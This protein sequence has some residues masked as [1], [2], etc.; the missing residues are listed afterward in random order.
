MGPE[1]CV[2]VNPAAGRAEEGQA[3]IEED[4]RLRGCK[5]EYTSRD[6]DIGQL[7]Y[8]RVIVA[9]GD[10]TL[11]DVINAVGIE[12][13]PTLGLLPLGTANDFA[14]SLGIPLDLEGALDVIERGERHAVDVI[15]VRGSEKERLGINV[16]AGGFSGAVDEELDADVKGRWG[17]FAYLRT[18]LGAMTEL[19]TYDI[20]LRFDDGEEDRLSSFNVAVANGRYVGGGIPVAP[21][22]RFD[23]GLL[24]VVVLKAGTLASLAAL[25]PRILVG[26]H[27]EDEMVE[28]RRARRLEVSSDPP[29]RF[30]VDGELFAKGDL[31]FEVV[32]RALTFIAG[33]PDTAA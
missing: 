11:N 16:S 23:D 18:A 7:G 31:Q 3:L 5:I 17:A 29:M 14:R 22:A 30:N 21:K 10:G 28:Y 27:A 26:E 8:Q 15:R 9:G 1:T 4:E 6:G 32:P 19:E 2:I 12:E 25:A 13:P 20:V 33:D 24:D